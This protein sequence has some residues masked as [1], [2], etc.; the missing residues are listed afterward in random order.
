MEA[1]T[2]LLA[3]AASVPLVGAETVLGV[4]IFHRHGDRTAKVTAPVNLT[5]LGASQ[6]LGSGNFYRYR[7]VAG[8][9]PHRIA[10][11]SS[12][13]AV[14]DQLHVMSPEDAVLQSSAQIFLQG[15]YPPIGAA[16][17]TLGNGTKVQAPLG[18]RQFVPVNVDD[19]AASSRQSE[20]KAMLQSGSGCSK[21]LASTK[22]YYDT[23]EYRERYIQTASFYQGLVP[24]I[25]PAFSSQ[26]ASFQNA[27][28]SKLPLDE[29]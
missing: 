5:S 25:E 2:L 11:L 19:M 27:Y 15:L 29:T 20:S 1:L 8:S 28:T 22:S 18:G 23:V 3:L 24:A 14:P 16:A 21:A 10:G 12:I 26:S 6:V 17:E 7:Y 13:V 4:Y 9:A